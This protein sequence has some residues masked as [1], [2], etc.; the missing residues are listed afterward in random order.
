MST[1]TTPEEAAKR[2]ALADFLQAFVPFAEQNGGADLNEMAAILG[3]L[4]ATLTPAQITAIAASPA[5]PA[6]RPH[7]PSD[8]FELP[9]PDFTSPPPAPG[10]AFTLDPDQGPAPRLAKQGVASRT[11]PALYQQLLEAAAKIPDVDALC[12]ETPGLPVDKIGTSWE[13][14]TWRQY[15]DEAKRFA[16]ALIAVGFQPFESVAICGFNHPCWFFAHVGAVAIGGLSA[17]TYTT[18]SSEACAYVAQDSRAR[19]VVVDTLLNLK[20]YVA[21]K[22]TLPNVVHAVVWGA[23]EV[24]PELSAGGWAITWKE[25][26]GRAS[27]V[28]DSTF[29]ALAATVE[30]KNCQVLIYTSGTTGAPKGVMMSHDSIAFAS[31]ATLE[32]LRLQA[33]HMHV[34][35]FLPLSHVA[36]QILDVGLPICNAARGVPTTVHCAR[37]DALKGTLVQTMQAVRPTMFFGVP[38]VWEKFVEGIKAKAA[39]A[40]TGPKTLG[41][42]KAFAVRVG[43]QGSLARQAGG[44]G[45]LPAGY[46]IASKAVHAK[47]REALGLDRVEVCMTGAAPIA[48]QTLDF[49]SGFGIDILEVYGMSE[50]AGMGTMSRQRLFKFGACGFRTFPMELKVDFVEGR[51]KEGEGELCFRGRHVMLGY[52]RNEEK[53]RE[54]IDSEGWMHSGDIGRIEADGSVY[55]TGRIKELIITA[56][57]ENIAPVPIE[58]RLK[59]LLPAV[60]NVVVV[61][62]RRKFNTLLVTLKMKPNVDTG[63]F[64]DELV[65]EATAVNPAVT[66][67]SA[68]VKDAQWHTYVQKGLDA[69]NDV[70][71]SNASRVQKFTIL[72][73]DL[74]LPGGELTATLKLKRNVVA[75]KYAVVIDAMY[76]G[77]E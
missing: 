68:A 9:G 14:Y 42:L 73:H 17:G 44:S 13:R 76:E 74:S 66:T 26:V 61:G 36:A 51:D 21:A 46:A 31:A 18:N 1:G 4:G 22:A 27:D 39:A 43:I 54:V 70:A 59:A 72:P 48:R 5:N 38:R 47:V 8:V 20:K 3:T 15:A 32:W 33:P 60:S 62:D 57:G 52:L 30:A 37:P 19:V 63:D 75:E 49:L 40:G 69:Y 53:T 56:G 16:K 2:A 35:S 6:A 64:F 29:D 25:F 67:A 77:C 28:A 34:V 41:Q 65:A 7:I 11:Y 24:P 55:I 12:V 45:E 58:Q 71:T 50:T 10:Q 23:D